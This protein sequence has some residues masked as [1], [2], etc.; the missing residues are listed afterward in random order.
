MIMLSTPPPSSGPPRPLSGSRG[1]RP[2]WV[3]R[4][5]EVFHLLRECSPSERETLL[6]EECGGDD[7]LAQR[8]RRLLA[9]SDQAGDLLPGE[10]PWSPEVEAELA[11]LKPEEASERI[12]P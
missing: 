12:G 5:E 8:V 2:E 7:K 3:V 10:T 9:A 11:R 4:A 1:P 6:A